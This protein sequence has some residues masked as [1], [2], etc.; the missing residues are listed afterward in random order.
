MSTLLFILG[1]IIGG[2]IGFIVSALVNIVDR[3]DDNDSL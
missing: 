1:L 2:S 3:E